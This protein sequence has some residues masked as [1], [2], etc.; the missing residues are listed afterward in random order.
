MTWA[1]YNTLLKAIK[2]AK[3]NFHKIP[4]PLPLLSTWANTPVPPFCAPECPSHLDT[5]AQPHSFLRSSF[6][7]AS[8]IFLST[9]SFP[10]TYKW[11]IISLTIQELKLKLKPVSTPFHFKLPPISHLS[12]TS[13]NWWC[14]LSPKSLSLFFCGLILPRQGYQQV[15]FSFDLSMGWQHVLIYCKVSVENEKGYY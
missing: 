2:Q 13:K 5:I 8:S 11:A 12:K 7:P 9:E 1:F 4:S 3:E 10:S 6:C 15:H 14:W